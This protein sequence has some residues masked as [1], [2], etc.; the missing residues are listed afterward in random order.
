MNGGRGGADEQALDWAV[1]MADP[2]AADWDGF[3][4]WL[5]EDPANSAHYDRIAAAAQDAAVVGSEEPVAANDV[6]PVAR[7]T[8][9]WIGGALAAMLVGAVGVGV[10]SERPQPF[11]VETAAGE[12]R[13][14]ALADGSSVVLAGGSRLALDRG[15]ARVASVERGQVLFRVRHDARDPFDVRVGDLTLTDLG[16]VFDVKITGRGTRVAV[17]EGAVMVDPAGAAMRLDPGQAVLSD[18]RTLR[19]EPSAVADVGS[20]QDGRLAFDNAPLSEVAEDLS[21]QLAR[22]VVAAPAVAGRT[23]RGTIATAGLKDD[24]ALLGTLLDVDV[25][26]D[27]G[28]WT[29]EPRQ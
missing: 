1:R 10:W 21:R 15:D 29:L 6:A 9:R 16:T 28:G 12:Q 26:Q 7:P 17:A 5:E 13:V 18:G 2:E 20:W 22:R 11:A 24:P 19:R 3:M 8:R 4:R 14:V 25:R 27:A 23:F